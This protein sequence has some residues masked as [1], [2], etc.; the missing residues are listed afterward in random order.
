VLA[1]RS[2][3]IDSVSLSAATAKVFDSIEATRIE[4]ADE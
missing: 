1:A 2:E 4:E 3:I